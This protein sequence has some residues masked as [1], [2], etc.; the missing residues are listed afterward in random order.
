MVKIF[1]EMAV[2]SISRVIRVRLRYAML[3]EAHRTMRNWL[4]PHAHSLLSLRKSALR[5][6]GSSWLLYR[7]IG[8][9]RLVE[10]RD[11]REVREVT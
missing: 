5:F 4:D 11:V 9:R 7:L 2:A 3:S 10:S 6:K 8:I 1:R